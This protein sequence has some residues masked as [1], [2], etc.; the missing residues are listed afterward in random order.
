MP[1]LKHVIIWLLF[2]LSGMAALIYEIS[3]SRQ[4]GLLLGHTVDAAAVV[5]AG[6]FGGMALG[7]W[8]A[9]VWGGRTRRPLWGYGVLE[10]AVALWGAVCA[11]STRWWSSGRMFPVSTRRIQ[12]SK[13]LPPVS[14]AFMLLLPAT[15]AMGA[16][17]PLFARAM[18]V[19]PLQMEIET[20]L[21]PTH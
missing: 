9:A 16:T 5:L 15:T 17:L 3:W 12:R 21:G 2:L 7:Y 20:S 1:F 19:R 14:L 18:S 6:Y 8:L 4:L 10:I 11:H 13:F